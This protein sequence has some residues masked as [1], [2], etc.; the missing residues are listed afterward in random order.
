[1]FELLDNEL[2]DTASLAKA[3][4]AQRY[5]LKKCEIEKSF[6]PHISFVPTLH[7]K[8]NTHLILCEVSNRPFPITI[9]EVFADISVKGMPVKIFVAYPKNAM[10][11]IKE[12]HN[13]ILK[14]K[15]Y[16]IGL[17]SIDDSK[18]ATVEYPGISIPLH[19]S[20]LDIS[21]YIKIIRPSVEE[22]FESYMIDGKPDVGLQKLGQLIENI[23][24][25]IAKQAKKKGKFTNSAFNPPKFIAQ[26]S[27]LDKM[28]TEKVIDIGILGNCKSFA[29][30]R[31]SV[32]HKPS[33]SKEVKT[34]EEKLKSNFL[35]GLKILEEIPNYAVKK[36]YKIIP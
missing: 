9:K 35:F 14:A 20:K 12:Y 4:I 15:E 19:L 25:N 8:T 3:K 21:K 17:L 18:I 7:W 36:W 6:S 31:N 26:S 29:K 10:T 11:D 33:T 27:L 1:M 13:D 32:S 34:I 24:L 5:A 23:V 2:F 30:E 28:I 16:G 22:A